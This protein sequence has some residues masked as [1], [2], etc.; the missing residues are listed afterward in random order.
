MREKQRKHRRDLV[1]YMGCITSLF[2]M[3]YIVP[4]TF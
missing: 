4:L 1:G 3:W 2:G